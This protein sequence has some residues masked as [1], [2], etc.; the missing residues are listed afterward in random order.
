MMANHWKVFK[1]KHQ[2][3]EEDIIE[4]APCSQCFAELVLMK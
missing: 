4:M 3:E 1:F 2:Y